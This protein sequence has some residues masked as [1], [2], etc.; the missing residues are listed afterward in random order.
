MRNVPLSDIKNEEMLRI[1]FSMMDFTRQ[2]IEDLKAARLALKFN[3]QGKV[4]RS[5]SNERSKNMNSA[6]NH[7]NTGLDTNEDI[8]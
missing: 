1:V 2:E 5:K 4:I 3:A 8:Q 7:S 6:S